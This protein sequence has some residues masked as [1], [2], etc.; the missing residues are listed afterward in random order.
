[1]RNR[2]DKKGI[3]P[4]IATV[5]VIGFTI[6]LALVIFS[7]GKTF[8]ET[9]TKGT[10]E[11]AEQQLD[12]SDL[13]SFEVK[14]A[15]YAGSEVKFTLENEGDITLDKITLRIS[16]EE[17]GQV[18]V[19]ELDIKLFPL[20]RKVYT[21][22]FDQQS[23]GSVVTKIELLRPTFTDDGKEVVCKNIGKELKVSEC[24]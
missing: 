13:V 4:L 5:L 6:A 17:D 15:C 3:S 18:E 10:G 1:M 2:R 24:E 22:Q 8:T 20:G 7:W 16:G 14:N 23:V 9:L 19:K 21:E 11:K 12:C